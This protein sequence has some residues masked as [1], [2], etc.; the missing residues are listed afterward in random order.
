MISIEERVSKLEKLVYALISKVDT[1]TYY[2]NAANVSDNVKIGNVKSDS[3]AVE[4]AVCEL[5]ETTEESVASLEQALCDL[6][7]EIG[8][9]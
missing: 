6:S 8:G 4:D 9:Q 1:I 7:E 2:Q 5:S 3:M